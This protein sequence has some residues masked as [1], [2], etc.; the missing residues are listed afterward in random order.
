[1]KV[2]LSC[3]YRYLDAE[4]ELTIEFHAGQVYEVIHTFE[5]E[6]WGFDNH[7]VYVIVNDHG[8]TMSISAE[9]VT[10]CE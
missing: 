4:D 2:K 7:T 5:H 1:M 3:D 8:E 6:S 9:V 10:V